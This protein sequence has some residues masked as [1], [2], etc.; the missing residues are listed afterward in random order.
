MGAYYNNSLKGKRTELL[1][2]LRR[3]MA[4][5][6]TLERTGHP[7]KIDQGKYIDLTKKFIALVDAELKSES[8]PA[9]DDARDGIF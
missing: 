9:W 2:D 8:I 7:S 5:Y 4:R 6:A 3:G 1:S